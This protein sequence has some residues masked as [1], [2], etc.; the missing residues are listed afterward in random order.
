M[1]LQRLGTNPEETMLT[2]TNPE[3][4][5]RYGV[6]SLQ[7][8]E[9]WVF[10]EFIGNGTNLSFQRFEKDWRKQNPDADDAD[11]E[12]FNDRY[13]GDEDSYELETEDGLKLGLSTLGGAYNVWVFESP[14]TDLYSEC[15]PCCPNAGDI[16]SPD[17]K[18]GVKTYTLP[19]DWF[20]EDEPKDE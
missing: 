8:L 15:S 1:A 5:I 11:W 10:D 19:P 13:E 14:F 3:T 7:S 2:N 17:P 16:N 6:V 12:E 9:D 18:Y 20:R 4:G